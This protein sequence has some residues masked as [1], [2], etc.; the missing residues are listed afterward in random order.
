MLRGYT[1]L[2]VCFAVRGSIIH[3]PNFSH[4]IPNDVALCGWDVPLWVWLAYQ[5]VTVGA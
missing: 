4:S 1:K 3:N 5:V 2:I